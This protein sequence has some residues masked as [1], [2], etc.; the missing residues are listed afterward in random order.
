M[1]LNFI[2]MADLS[3]VWPVVRDEVLK[4]VEYSNGRYSEKTIIDGLLTGMMQ[5]WVL[6]NNG[7]GDASLITQVVN[8]PTGLK[9]CDV[10]LLGGIESKSWA[11]FITSQLSKWA[12]SLGCHSLQIIGRPGWEKVLK[13]WGKTAVMLEK[14]LGGDHG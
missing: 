9:V 3:N 6:S 12:E 8:Y 1:E 14:P 13:N 10:I 11:E 2:E 7:S 4:A 5:L